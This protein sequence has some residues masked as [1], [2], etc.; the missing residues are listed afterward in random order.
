RTASARGRTE[1]GAP[2][3]TR[4]A[5]RGRDLTETLGEGREGTLRQLCFFDPV[6]NRRGSA[7]ATTSSMS[8]SNLSPISSCESGRGI[9][10]RR[11]KCFGQRADRPEDHR[12]RQGLRRVDGS[13]R[14]TGAGAIDQRAAGDAPKPREGRAN[15]QRS[16]GLPA[17]ARSQA[18]LPDEG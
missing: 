9:V 7:T 1:S 2:N 17:A 14:P 12:G 18:P 11:E 15:P 4:G 8:L 10:S 5:H 13:T 6:G 16:D 3:R